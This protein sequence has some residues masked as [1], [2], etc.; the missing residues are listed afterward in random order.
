MYFIEISAKVMAVMLD[1]AHEVAP[2]I[3]NKFPDESNQFRGVMVIVIGFRLA[4]HV[5]VLSFFWEKI[6]HG[7]KDLFTEPNDRLIEESPEKK[8][9][10][11]EKTVTLEEITCS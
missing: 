5:R 8:Q 9:D 10:E 3:Q 7:E 6:F 4:F 11:F 2:L 1:V